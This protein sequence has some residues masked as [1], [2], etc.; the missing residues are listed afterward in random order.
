MLEPVST[1]LSL[2]WLG[3]AALCSASRPGSAVSD[4][5]RL[6][7]AAI[8]SIEASTERSHFLFGAKASA[9]ASLQGLAHE[10]AENLPSGNVSSGLNAVAIRLAM[11]FVRALPDPLPMPEFAL[12]ADGAISLDWIRSSHRMLSI[13]VDDS[14]RLAYTWIDGTDKGRGVLYFDGVAVPPRLLYDIRRIVVDGDTTVR[15][16]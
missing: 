9:L 6:V 4:E 7:T 16:A 10:Y 11:D 2:L 14:R 12:E 15:A 13:S 1:G 3:H 8:A 5:A